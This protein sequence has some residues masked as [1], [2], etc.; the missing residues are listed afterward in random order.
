MSFFGNIKSFQLCNRYNL[1]YVLPSIVDT[2]GY[3]K[4]VTFKAIVVPTSWNFFSKL[5]E[6]K[7]VIF[8][9]NSVTNTYSIVKTDRFKKFDIS[10]VNMLEQIFADNI[11][12]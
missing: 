6:E 8:W 10:N 7:T 5:E 11:K 1:N 4:L 2:I 9:R 3:I 12:K